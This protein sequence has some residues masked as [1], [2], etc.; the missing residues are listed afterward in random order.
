VPTQLSHQSIAFG[1]S[2]AI[3]KVL[4]WRGY[5]QLCVYRNA[6]NLTNSP[7]LQL[8]PWFLLIGLI[9]ERFHAICRLI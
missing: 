1:V 3:F 4:F 6:R 5:K 2:D 7:N 8:T 9:P